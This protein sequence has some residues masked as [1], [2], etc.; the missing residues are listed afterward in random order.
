ME[1]ETGVMG[2]KAKEHQGL[3]AFTSSM[4]RG[5]EQ[6]HSQSPQKEPNSANTMISDY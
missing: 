6:I 1:A 2:L 5:M 3:L 4:E